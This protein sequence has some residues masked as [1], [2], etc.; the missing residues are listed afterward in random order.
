MFI[1]THTQK[2]PKRIEYIYIY[3]IPST[4]NE[5]KMFLQ[6]SRKKEE[7]KRMLKRVVIEN[8]F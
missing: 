7:K 1:E 5:K 6:E 3:I 8:W 4:L 2:M